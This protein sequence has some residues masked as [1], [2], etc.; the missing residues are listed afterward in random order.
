MEFFR[1]NGYDIFKIFLNQIG[2][3][4][5]ALIMTIA[6]YSNDKLYLGSSIFCTVFF[7]YLLYVMFYDMGTSDKPSIDG[8]RT[9][10]NPLKGLWISLWGN[11]LNILCGVMIAVFSLFIVMQN[12]VIV[13]D[14]SGNEISVFTRTEAYVSQEA[15]SESA[16][17]YVFTEVKL[18]SDN[19]GT[20]KTS[21]YADAEYSEVVNE[22]GAVTYLYDENGNELEIYSDDGMKLS[23]AQKSVKNWASNLYGVP[24][25]IATF[26]QSMYAGIRDAFFSSSSDFFY[27]FTP[28]PSVLFCTLG[29]Y[30]GAKGKRILF[31][32]PERKQKPPKY[33]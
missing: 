4:M 26:L 17:E 16:A 15:D 33:R 1:K 11:S 6:T 10:F 14:A 27:L 32:L 25:V 31:F 21:E 28:I 12:P 23:T 19:G 3:A 18:Y 13:T 2:L 30:M 22:N 20:V 24:F 29:Y 5:L 9:P 7:V 8:G